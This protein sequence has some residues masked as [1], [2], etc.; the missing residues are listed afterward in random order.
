VGLTRSWQ[1]APLREEGAPGQVI[2]S[3]E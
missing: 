3:R 2:S 1:V